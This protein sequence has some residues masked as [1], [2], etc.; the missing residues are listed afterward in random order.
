[1]SETTKL[2]LPLIAAAQAQKH[3]THNEALL[4][5]DA[6]LHLEVMDKD[7]D[8]PPANP[9]DGDRYIVG[10]G[11]SGAWAGEA[12]H[13]A[14]FQDGVWRFHPP[15]IGWRAFVRDE[16]ALYV[17]AQS[18][19]IAVGG[20]AGGGALQNVTLFGLG[21]EADAVNPFSARVGKALWAATT[22]AEGGTGDLRYTLNKEAAANVLSLLF[23]RG[24]S[25]RAEMGL[26]GDD[27]F[28]IKVSANGSMW[29]EAMRIDGASGRAAF[30][31]GIAPRPW[32]NL[33]D[34]ATVT[35]DAAAGD[36]FRL[37]A[38][39]S[40]TLAKPVNL[41]DGMRFILRVTNS[42]NVTLTLNAAFAP[43]SGSAPALRAGAGQ[44]NTF[45]CVYDAAADKVF[46]AW[47]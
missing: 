24:W 6:L 45:D 25:G 16:G 15:Q 36:R 38:G 30:P 29:R 2:R 27:D 7:R 20:G 46:Y 41:M 40:R 42:A 26:I 21:T 14:A 10:A 19:W 22:V 37:A 5:L 18:G 8:A 4:K 17:K 12:G 3:V 11:A 44:S 31:G 33:T 28:Q 39:G 1:M 43:F 35:I 32:V 13:V 47:Y 9:A 23:Q 34:A